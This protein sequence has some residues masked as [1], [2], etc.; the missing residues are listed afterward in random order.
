[1]DVEGEYDDDL[2]DGQELAINKR[3]RLDEKNIQY[4]L[5]R[6][7]VSSAEQSV[8]S[9][10][11]TSGVDTQVAPA[12]SISSHEQRQADLTW[13]SFVGDAKSAVVDTFYGQFKSSVCITVFLQ[14]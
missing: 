11:S 2:E 9:S 7:Q 14:C 4:E 8:D 3:M 10:A 1:M 13:R 5:E 12:P 6:Y